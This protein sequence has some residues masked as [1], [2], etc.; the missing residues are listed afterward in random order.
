MPREGQG[1]IL[2][3]T[4]HSDRFRAEK[5]FVPHRLEMSLASDRREQNRAAE[6]MGSLLQA[7][8]VQAFR[9]E[10]LSEWPSLAR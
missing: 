8:A 10:A 3:R 4:D 2:V 7:S 6:A 1:A 9:A 5:R